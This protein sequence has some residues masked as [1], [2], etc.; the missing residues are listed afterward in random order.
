MDKKK[1]VIRGIV[2]SDKM[3]KGIVVRVDYR[4]TDSRFKKFVT[5][6]KRIM[7]HDAENQGKSGDVV[8]IESTRPVSRM[9][10]YNLVQVVEKARD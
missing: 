10:R 3:D 8:E 2:V 5:R 7:A 4:K 9:K 6:S 1:K